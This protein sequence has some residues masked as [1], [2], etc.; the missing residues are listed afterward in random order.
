MDA[1]V[2]P[3]RLADGC[4][5]ASVMPAL[6]PLL[7][8][9]GWLR[10]IQKISRRLLLLGADGE[11]ILKPFLS[12][13]DLPVRAVNKEATR[14]LLDRAASP[15]VPGGEAV[16][17]LPFPKNRTHPQESDQQKRE[18]IDEQVPSAEP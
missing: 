7:E 1:G 15:P 3:R 10:P 13:P 14:H 18:K 16:A 4:F 17:S 9:E 5:N 6:L 8:Q 12:R 11:V 2:Q